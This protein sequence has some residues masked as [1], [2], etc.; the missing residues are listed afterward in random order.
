METITFMTSLLTFYLKGEIKAEQNFLKLKKPNTIL[1]FIPLGAKRYNVPINQ[2]SSVGTDFRLLFKDLLVGI[3]ECIAAFALFG[4]S[5]I[6]AL[7]LLFVGAFTVINSFQTALVISTTSGADYVLF[8]LIFEKSKALTAEAAIN[9]MISTRLDD[10]NVRTHTENQTA[11]LNSAQ[12]ASTE[13][14]INAI[15]SNNKNG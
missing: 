9:R 15:N 14:I 5:V 10:T 12:A 8:F 2:I 1:A 11:A 6:W 13:A 7:I 4:T 3:I